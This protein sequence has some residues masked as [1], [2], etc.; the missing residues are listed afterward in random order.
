ML[1]ASCGQ[2]YTGTVCPHCHGA[3][4]V[5]SV[6][7]QHT[8]QERS[9]VIDAEVV[10]EEHS[11]YQRSNTQQQG[12]HFRYST[13]NMGSLAQQQSCLPFFITFGLMLACGAQWGA[14]AAIGFLFFYTIGSVVGLL[15]TMGKVLNGNS[16]NPWLLRCCNWVAASLLTQWLAS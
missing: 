13:W 15:F 2:E 4:P 5:R 12:Q 7:A 9:R 6:H 1:C 14:L 16:V 8:E 11:S 3:L 10:N